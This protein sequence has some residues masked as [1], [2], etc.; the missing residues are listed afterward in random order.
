MPTDQLILFGLLFAVFALL[1]WGRIRYDLVAFGALTVALITGVVP[2]DKAFD[3]F[4]HPATV[5]V[6][7]VLVVSQGLSNSG[8]IDLIARYVVD[9]GRSLA[10]H[11]SIMA[12]VG[13]ALSAVIN[14]VAALVL[15]MPVD[16]Q[17]AEKA[18]RSPAVTLMPLSFATILGGMVTLIGTPPNIVVSGYREQTLGEPFRM[19]DYAPVGLVC[20]VAGVAFVAL[21]GWRLIPAAR[22]EVN[23]GEE[24]FDLGAY[25]SELK[26]NEESPVIGKLVAELD[27]A[28]DNN[29]VTILGVL[30]HGSHRLR[31]HRMHELAANDVII[32]EGD[33]KAIGKF[34]NDLKISHAVL[35]EDKDAEVPESLTKGDQAMIEVV[36]RPGAAIEGHTARRLGLSSLYNIKLLGVSRRGQRVHER[37]RQMRLE[38]GDILLLLGPRA[39]LMT[40]S[41]RLGLLP[42]ADRGLKEVSQGKALL[43]IGMFAAAIA[44]ASFGVLYLA[45]A[46]A[47]VA[48]LFVLLNI[49]PVNEVYDSIEWPVIVLLGSMIPIGTALEASGGTSLI[50]NA[51]VNLSL[52]A[53]TWVVLMILMIV[54]MFL[55]DVLNNTATAVIA[56]P[57]AVDVARVLEVKPDAFLMAVAI[58]AS[59]AFLTP[60]G[61]KNNTL[62]LGPGGYQFGDYWRMGLP[63]EILIVAI[64]IPMILLVWPL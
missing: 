54:T 13:A 23:T 50:A 33:A 40:M 16:M 1:I 21:I 22:R 6:A 60:I 19:F 63:L 29:D 8:A 38:A 44:L 62:I 59:C 55:S 37:L 7:L 15:L 57:I 27:E 46:L 10:A 5:I 36:V 45:V 32:V 47:A 31:W 2:T 26:V 9:T 14:N 61:H 12:G 30:S 4:G 20:A 34:A 24:L 49:V 56:A 64:S 53:P 39:R 35:E 58:A 52:G 11:I 41:E 25:I 18:K 17:A 43:A 3:G 28:S 42:L 48:V 51:L